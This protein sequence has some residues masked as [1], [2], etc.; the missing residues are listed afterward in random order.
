[1]HGILEK[2]F[3]RHL[4]LKIIL[5]N[6]GVKNTVQN[7]GVRMSKILHRSAQRYKHHVSLERTISLGLDIEIDWSALRSKTTS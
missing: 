7:R 3:H 5:G 2:I 1:M 6:L 4:F